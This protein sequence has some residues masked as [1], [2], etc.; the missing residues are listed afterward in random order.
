MGPNGGPEFWAG[1]RGTSATDRSSYFGEGVEQGAAATSCASLLL[2]LARI[3]FC[4]KV[5]YWGL[6]VG[7]TDNPC[8]NVW[9]ICS[10]EA[11]YAGIPSGD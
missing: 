2:R 9:V 1:A 6:S 8:K 4:R 10:W 11:I 7:Y 5:K 3:N